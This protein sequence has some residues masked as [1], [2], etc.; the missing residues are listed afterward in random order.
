MPGDTTGDLVG[1]EVGKRGQLSLSSTEIH[2]ATARASAVRVAVV[3]SVIVTSSIPPALTS[4]SMMMSL[5]RH[6]FVII[7]ES[8]E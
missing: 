5:R 7:N 6:F 8:T 3:V 1:S 4:G 2:D